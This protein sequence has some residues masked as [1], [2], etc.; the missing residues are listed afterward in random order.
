MLDSLFRFPADSTMSAMQV[1]SILDLL[2]LP[3]GV[4]DRRFRAL[5]LN[6]SARRFLLSQGIIVGDRSRTGRYN[7]FRAILK[8]FV[9]RALKTGRATF[10]PEF[11][12]PAPAEGGF[13]VVVCPGRIQ[14]SDLAFVVGLPGCSTADEQAA[15]ERIFEGFT[16]GVVLMG[17]DLRHKLLNSRALEMFGLKR[18][19]TIGK[20]TSE[21]NP[22]AQAKVQESQLRQF[23]QAR[24]GSVQEDYVL[25]SARFGVLRG[26]LV[27]WPIWNAQGSS[28]G[29][30]M[31][32]DALV[33]RAGAAEPDRE[34]LE[35]LGREA[36]LHG[37]PVYYTHVDGTVYLMN[38]AAGAL[39]TPG[40]TGRP[41]NLK[42]D[43]PWVHPEVLSALY[44]NLLGGALVTTA[45]AEIESPAGTKTM[46]IL[47]RG[48]RD[49][50]D[51]VSRICFVLSDA[52]EHESARRLLADTVRSLASE[53]E[54]L[55]KIV[56][57]LDLPVAVV[58]ENLNTI[59]INAA[60]ARRLGMSPDDA[61]G[62]P[63]GQ[64][65]P[66]VG[67]TGM[68]DL[69]R[70]VLEK[71]TDVHLAR[72]EHVMRSGEV[73]PME[74]S[75]YPVRIEGRKCCLAIARE[76]LGREKIEA[77]AAKWESRYRAVVHNLREAVFVHDK[78]GVIEDLNDPA[79]EALGGEAGAIGRPGA[80]H[81]PLVLEGEAILDA[82]RK[83]IETGET[84]HQGLM[85]ITRVATGDEHFVEITHV[86]LTDARGKKA[87]LVTIVHSATGVV[88]L[89]RE[90]KRYTESL[91][92]KVDER[93]AE[94]SAAKRLL[95]ESVA[96][97]AAVARSGP[98]MASL[99]DAGS[100]YRAFLTQARQTLGADFV[101]LILVEKQAG[102]AQSAYYVE[103]VPPP[104]G[105]LDSGIVETAIAQL[106]LGEGA[107]E[108]VRI[109]KP[110][111]L[112]AETDLGQA[113]GLLVAWR[114]R[115]EFSEMD[116]GLAGLLSAQMAVALPIT[117]YVRE[118][119]H[120]RDR[121]DCLRRIAVRV[122]GASSVEEAM[123]LVAEEIAGAL[124]V[125]RMMWI[126]EGGPD[127]LWAS[128]V[129]NRSGEVAPRALR[130]GFPPGARAAHV[131]GLES[132]R[133][134]SFCDIARGS[135]P[136]DSE[137][138]GAPVRA[139]PFAGRSGP[140]PLALRLKALLAEAGCSRDPDVLPAVAPVMLSESSYGLLC[141]RPSDGEA[142]APD[143][144]CFICVAASTIA[145][146][147]RAADAA[148][149][150]R[151][152]EAAGDSVGDIVHDLKYPLNKVREELARL[153]RAG[154]AAALDKETIA[155]L[156]GE[157][158]HLGSLADELSAVSNPRHRS[159]EV[160][161]I[162]QAVDHCL[163]LLADDLGGKGV[164]V[165]K[166]LGDVPPI[167]ADRR[168]VT[169]VLLNLLVN[170]VEAVAA[171]GVIGISAKVIRD[172]VGPGM[173][174]LVFEDSGPGVP[175]A[176]IHKVFDA[177]FTTKEGGTGLGLFSARK[178]AQANGGGLTCEI[179]TGG[180]S[181]FVARFPAAVG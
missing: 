53:K 77:E 16:V 98:L 153:D 159:P 71:G 121:A 154:G 149:A 109:P 52:T 95:A 68:V 170:S 21:V 10:I 83:A 56:D 181:R 89:E 46:R 173:V 169:R 115:G 140:S 82:Q 62:K 69:M 111:V 55:D 5:S 105:A 151:R 132:V 165:K 160:I 87:G 176:C 45:M 67:Q 48:I 60:T 144:T 73:M 161:D 94:L 85:K 4:M 37:P 66:T 100:V 6:A 65:V 40:V 175:E 72:F 13:R 29:I 20:L 24:Q 7:A 130:I 26:R 117:R 141:A 158:G 70:S 27:L 92:K 179:G 8:P 36:H 96:K 38:A 164:R 57:A 135:G 35:L 156:M 113:W 157:L 116:A 131:K 136:G 118:L 171:D 101:N 88:K 30:V 25:A 137:P 104:K 174:G 3:V 14:S 91:R 90:I 75:I 32:V 146:M 42:T 2:D 102:G 128:E 138:G 120:G 162:E 43:V 22:S 54:I 172:G 127:Q 110:D 148:S 41:A 99:T 11:T 78:D 80:D 147:W 64:V 155:G 178:R 76:T 167:Y 108:A 17:A 166:E 103:G 97:I 9:T 47:A 79:A 33:P 134:K 44:A 114:S 150:V 59:R 34:T 61:V 15:L 49:V 74:M 31:L 81:V 63:I 145:S 139:C 58:D 50:G 112:L 39:V 86:P 125:D 129:F 106:A 180:K 177:F 28:E 126:V 133:G 19:E 93:T 152:L 143:D 122:A 51:I 163:G 168:D 142:F 119:E 23:I 18:G 84:Q 1:E 107:R 123:R 124:P 12:L